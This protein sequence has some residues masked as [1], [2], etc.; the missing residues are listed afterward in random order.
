VPK[1]RRSKLRQ[2][3]HDHVHAHVL[4]NVNDDVV[5][6]VLVTGCL[7]LIENLS[8]TNMIAQRSAQTECPSEGPALRLC[9]TFG[10][11]F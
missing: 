7:R 6:H 4:V 3:D 10:A 8:L 2:A 5:V 1:A 9:R 11:R